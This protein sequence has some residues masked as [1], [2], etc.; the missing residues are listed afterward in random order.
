MS[1]Q[2]VDPKALQSSEVLAT[3][4]AS[5]C[6]LEGVFFPDVVIKD[7]KSTDQSHDVQFPQARQALVVH[8]PS[9][10]LG[11]ASH[12]LSINKYDP[13]HREVGSFFYHIFHSANQLKVW[14][15]DIHVD[16]VHKYF[17][18]GKIR[19]LQ[20]MV[21]TVQVL[22]GYWGLIS[23]ASPFIV[24][25]VRLNKWWGWQFDQ[26]YTSYEISTA[27]RHKKTEKGLW[28]SKGWNQG[29]TTTQIYDELQNN[30]CLPYH[31]PS[32]YIEFPTQEKWNYMFT[33]SVF[34][35]VIYIW[36]AGASHPS[37]SDG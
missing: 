24:V 26:Q 9:Q 19:S 28:R 37:H 16:W 14:G 17:H 12:C 6:L 13:W 10:G 20:T 4:H 5:I 21:V 35:N 32:C 2:R 36:L 25:I 27:A 1:Y 8:P 31:P 23:S 3:Y 33:S 30:L 29:H 34:S 11:H 22:G 7:A 18:Q 15:I